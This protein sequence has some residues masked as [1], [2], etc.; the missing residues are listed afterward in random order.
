MSEQSQSPTN[1]PA[2]RHT[3]RRPSL[4]VSCLIA[5]AAVVLLGVVLSLS[6]SP[7][8]PEISSQS[9][10]FR[11]LRG[12]GRAML[13]YASENSGALP[14]QLETLVDEQ[15][16]VSRQL[17]C[18]WS[19]HE[20][21]A[22]DYFYVTGLA[23]RD[24]PNWIIAFDDPACTKGEGANILYL[25]GHVEY[26]REPAS[27]QEVQRFKAAYEKARGAAAVIIPPH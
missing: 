25:D 24:P 23:I 7:P 22:C 20:E 2:P 6:L 5:G 12:I 4:F 13:E 1:L 14:P 17:V 19:G 26:V 18:P 21:P 10:S 15:L 11:N 3:W 8:A 27:S 9:V 16:Y